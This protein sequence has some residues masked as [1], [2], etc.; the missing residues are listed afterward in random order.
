MKPL[1]ERISLTLDENVIKAI[2]DL[3]IQN[4]RSFSAYVNIVL[5]KHIETQNNK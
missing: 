2:K 1:K 5:K 3:A 4:D